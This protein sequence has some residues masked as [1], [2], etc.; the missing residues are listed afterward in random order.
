MLPMSCSTARALLVE[1]RL[2]RVGVLL[3]ALAPL[4]RLLGQLVVALLHRQLRAP[5]PVVL[6]EQQWASLLS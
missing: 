2:H 1:L 4:E 3:V 5:V 6:R